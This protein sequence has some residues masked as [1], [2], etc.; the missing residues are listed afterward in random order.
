MDKMKTL[1][2]KSFAKEHNRETYIEMRFADQVISFSSQYG[3][4]D[5]GSYSL[6]NVAGVPMQYPEYHHSDETALFRTYGPWWKQAPSAQQRFGWKN[7]SFNAEDFIDLSYT[8]A[9]Y[10]TE[11]TIYETFSPGA[12]VRVLACDRSP[13]DHKKS[14]SPCRWEVLWEG[15]NH[16]ADPVARKFVCKSKQI[17]FKTR[18]IRVEFNSTLCS[19]YTELDAISLTGYVSL[20]NNQDNSINLLENSHLLG[21]KLIYGSKAK[22]IKQ[23]D[24]L[25]VFGKK[26]TYDREATE[27]EIENSGLFSFM[28][29][30]ILSYQLS[31]LDFQAFARLSRSCK[32]MWRLCGDAR[33]YR[34]LNLKSY[35]PKVTNATLCALQQRCSMLE[36]L[37][38]SWCGPLGMVTA[39]AFHR[40]LSLLDGNLEI[41]RLAACDFLDLDSIS[42]ITKHCPKLRELDLQSCFVDHCYSEVV[43]PLLSSLSEL[44][45]LNLARVQIGDRF[46][47][48]I[49]NSCRKLQHINI[50]GNRSI[51][52][53]KNVLEA[54]TNSCSDL[55]SLDISRIRPISEEMGLH[56]LTRCIKLEELD[57]GWCT[58]I[59]SDG[60]PIQELSKHC[61]NLKKVFLTSCEYVS[62]QDVIAL[63][64][65]LFLEQVDLLGNY[66]ISK[67]SIDTLLEKCKRLT[68][69]SVTHSPNIRSRHVMYWLTKYP[70]VSIK[71]CSWP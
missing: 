43:F 28:P 12:V 59:N 44:T 27:E 54:I 45:Y 40:F 30:E 46:L 56:L 17:D 18:Y 65:C 70:K 29:L 9:L 63:S 32:Y 68:L 14:E 34:S 53:L 26:L 35:W 66:R 16:V 23:L 42:V 20:P 61:K 6:K 33:F 49:F 52:C 41:L 1:F 4:E 15:E 57:A 60:H 7:P 37:D 62:S 5:V 11:V 31:Y 2:N 50:S 38:F 3:V 22:L 55:R 71:K 64:D 8:K 10:P 36:E 25:S 47:I 69:L 24:H 13:F 48:P 21:N 51:K 67:N 39:E 58:Q 19:Y